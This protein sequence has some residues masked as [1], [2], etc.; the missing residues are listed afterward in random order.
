MKRLL[1]RLL[2][3]GITV[4][5]FCVNAINDPPY[6]VFGYLADATDDPPVNYMKVCAPGRSGEANASYVVLGISFPR[7]YT[8]VAASYDGGLDR[9]CVHRRVARP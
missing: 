7:T 3:Y 9:S 5:T 4:C 1:V 6:E 8:A 2:L